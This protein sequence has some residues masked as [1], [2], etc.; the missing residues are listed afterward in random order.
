[1]SSRILG[2]NSSHNKAIMGYFLRLEMSLQRFTGSP[3]SILDELEREFTV[4]QLNHDNEIV[5]HHMLAYIQYII[6]NT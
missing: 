1:M 6:F 4:V 2:V 3:L 5:S